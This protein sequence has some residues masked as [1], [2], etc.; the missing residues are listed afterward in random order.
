MPENGQGEGDDDKT[1]LKCTLFRLGLQQLSA[2]LREI[3]VRLVG[4]IQFLWI[5]GWLRAVVHEPMEGARTSAEAIC[6]TLIE[7]LA[8]GAEGL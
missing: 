5:S 8:R 4:R 7:E 2:D 1:S 6:K 3:G